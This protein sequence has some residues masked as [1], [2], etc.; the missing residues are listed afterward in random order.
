LIG[1]DPILKGEEELYAEDNIVA[2]GDFFENV[3]LNANIDVF[4]CKDTLEH[5]S[6]PKQFLKKI[7]D[8]ARDDTLLLFQFP[9]L[10]SLL[11]DCRF[12]QV[13]HQHLNYFS[14]KSILYMLDEMGCRL[15]DY[16]VN[17]D[18]WG[19]ILIAFQKGKDN[20][21]KKWEAWAISSEEILE[22]YSAF[23][24][25]ME[26]T[27]MRLEYFTDEVLYGYG[28][29]L[30]LPVL[31][32][33]LKNDLSCLN[34]I[35]DDSEEK[36]GL[37]YINLPVSIVHSSKIDDIADAVVLLTAIFS[38]INMRKILSKVLTLKPKHIIYPLRTI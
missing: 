15:L 6:H 12:D 3:D 27:S 31:S 33:N 25:D 7:V 14:M 37:Y 24:V 4:I 2:V 17:Y 1:I 21:E 32:Y 20:S 35:I 10:E 28:A 5:V 8:K 9:L 13:F 22:R 34:C 11:T 23:K 26:Q 19:S 30:M 16:A 18:H 29:A 36:D 38:K